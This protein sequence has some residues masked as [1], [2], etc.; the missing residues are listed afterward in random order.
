MNIYRNKQDGVLYKVY[1][2]TSKFGRYM[3]VETLYDAKR[4]RMSQSGK[5]S[6]KNMELAYTM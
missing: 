4:F 6:M 3:E 5:F 2:V 1:L